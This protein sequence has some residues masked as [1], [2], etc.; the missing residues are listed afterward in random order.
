MQKQLLMRQKLYINK[1]TFPIVSLPHLNSTKDFE[2]GFTF[3]NRAIPLICL[4]QLK[5]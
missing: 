1:I 2:G 4:Q 3:L 5:Y